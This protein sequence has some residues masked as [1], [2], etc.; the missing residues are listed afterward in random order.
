MNKYIYLKK[1][2]LSKQAILLWILLIVVILVLFKIK[3]NLGDNNL[4]IYINSDCL[5]SYG[6]V[7]I[8]LY[9]I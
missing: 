6:I 7:I 8:Q 5:F 4:S 9:D 3:E 1:T 2:I